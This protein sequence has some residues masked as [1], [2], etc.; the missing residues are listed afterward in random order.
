M[1]TDE[2]LSQPKDTRKLVVGVK[3]KYRKY[4]SVIE[5][6]NFRILK[7]YYFILI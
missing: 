4:G 1:Y 7:G 3:N 6:M 2:M 5:N